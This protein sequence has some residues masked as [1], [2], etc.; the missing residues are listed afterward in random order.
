MI[1]ITHHAVD[2]VDDDAAVDGTADDILVCSMQV[3]LSIV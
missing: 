3:A 2:G 1:R